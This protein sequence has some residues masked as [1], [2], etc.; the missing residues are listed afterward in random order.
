MVE[1]GYNSNFAF[2]QY[3][4][5]CIQKKFKFEEK[6]MRIANPIYDVFFKYLMEDLEIARRLLS[7]II[8]ED[9]VELTVHPQELLT[10]SEKFE[11]LILR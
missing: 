2:F 7:A 11:I 6:T 9:I 4:W 3:F 5:L 1:K 10:R 8:S